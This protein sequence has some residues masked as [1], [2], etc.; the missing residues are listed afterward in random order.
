[1]STARDGRIVYTQ[2]LDKKGGIVADVTVT[3]LAADRFLVV[4]SDLIHRRIEPLIRRATAARR[5][6]PGH[7]HHL[8]RPRCCPCRGPRR[9]S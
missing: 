1:M 4:A 9:V 6:C 7:R 2:W 3:Q 5:D 8:R